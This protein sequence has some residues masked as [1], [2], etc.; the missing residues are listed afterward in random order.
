ML[1]VFLNQFGDFK[2]KNKAS[3]T[4]YEPKHYR[5]EAKITRNILLV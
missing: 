1:S 5:H 2:N 3:L 4:L